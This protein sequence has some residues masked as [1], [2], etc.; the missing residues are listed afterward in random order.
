MDLSKIPGCSEDIYLQDLSLNIKNV[1][2]DLPREEQLVVTINYANEGDRIERETLNAR[3]ETHV[4]P[5]KI[6]EITSNN[7]RE[8]MELE[9]FLTLNSVRNLKSGGEEV[10]SAIPVKTIGRNRF[11]QIWRSL[12]PMVTDAIYLAVR[13]N[14]QEWNWEG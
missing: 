10:F 12:P 1:E 7:Y 3:R 9:C 14:N 4:M 11:N 6:I 2:L 13:L 8:R 5:D